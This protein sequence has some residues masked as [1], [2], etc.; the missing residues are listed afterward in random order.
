ML[1]SKIEKLRND[2]QEETKE[3]VKV[4]VAVKVVDLTHE[5]KRPKLCCVQES[6]EA[7]AGW[8]ADKNAEWAQIFNFTLKISDRAL[9][10]T[11]KELT[12]LHIRICCSEVIAVPVSIIPRI[13][14]YSG[15]AV[16]WI[17]G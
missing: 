2:D 8:E 14:Q 10:L 17:L 12:D 3:P 4:E 6:K 5:S 7:R 13:A 1:S 9:L 11:G 16:Y 15:T